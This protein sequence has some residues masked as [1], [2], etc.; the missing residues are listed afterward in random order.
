MHIIRLPLQ[1]LI[2]TLYLGILTEKNFNIQKDFLKV[3]LCLSGDIQKTFCFLSNLSFKVYKRANVSV[4][5]QVFQFGIRYFVMHIFSKAYNIQKCKSQLCLTKT[6]IMGLK[7]IYTD[8]QFIILNP[9]KLISFSYLFNNEG[10][11][12]RF[13]FQYII[14]KRKL[15]IIS[16]H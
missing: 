3:S 9:F 8:F 4:Y 5:L 7:V 16:L 1:L 11:F 10:L 15:D 6:R 2:S 14:F 12:Y 13:Y